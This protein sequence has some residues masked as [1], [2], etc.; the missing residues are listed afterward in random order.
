MK[1]FLLRTIQAALIV[2][3]CTALG[4]LVFDYTSGNAEIA[5][6]PAAPAR[7]VTVEFTSLQTRD[8][9]EH[10]EL[11]GTILPAGDATI[12]ARVDGHITSVAVDVGET[13]T[14][15]QIIVT[16][17]NSP[18]KIALALSE[19]SVRSAE[20]QLRISQAQL[21]YPEKN[22]EYV[23]RLNRKGFSTSLNLDQSETSL[24][25]A[26]A[27]VELSEIRL[28]EAT[29]EK[30]RIQLA[31][32]NARVA[33]PF[34]GVI[35]QRFVNP[36]HFVRA[37]DPLLRVIDISAVL[38]AAHVVE[39]DYGSMAVGQVAEIRADALSGETFAGEVVRVSPVLDDETRT[40]VVHFRIDNPGGRLRPGMHAHVS[41]TVQEHSSVSVLPLACLIERDGEPTVFV[42]EG[43]PRTARSRVISVGRVDEEFVEVVS[44]ISA[45]D[46][47]VTLGSHLLADGQVVAASDGDTGK[48]LAEN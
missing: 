13:V 47:I 8:L 24:E 14:C 1:P 21:D 23:R 35:A 27:N 16:F 17:D 6:A 28:Q 11:T 38:V 45:E 19:A 25:I 32:D 37:G 30:Q 33:A 44:G 39:N 34:N 41:V 36:A 18:Q 10:V 9:D 3:A 40:A 7:P 46:R 29:A 31:I 48:V 43:E 5:V 26:R 12:A 20:V 2:L 22:A 15:D 42:L 4:L